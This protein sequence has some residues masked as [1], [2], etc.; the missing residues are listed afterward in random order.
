MSAVRETGPVLTGV[1]L[2]CTLY[3]EADSVTA[4]L[5]SVL[6][7][8]LLP[9]EFVIVDGGSTDGTS[10][11][12]ARYL[13]D[14]TTPTRVVHRIDQECNLRHSPGPVAKGRNVA[15]GLAS[16][17]LIAVTDAGCRLDP[18]WLEK[19]TARWRA[20]EDVDVIGG[21]YLPDARTHF[22]RC[23]AATWLRSS[24][25]VDPRSFMP[26]SRSLAMRREAWRRAGGY[27]EHTLLAEDT[28]FDLALRSSGC[29][30]AFAPEAV[31]YWRVPHS[32]AAFA[33][34]V[35]RY[36]YGDGLNRILPGNL[37]NVALKLGIAAA[38]L[39]ASAAVHPAFLALLVA[40]WTALVFR[41]AR[42][43]MTPAGFLK[44][45]PCLVAVKIVSD[46]SYLAGYLRGWA[47]PAPPP[48]MAR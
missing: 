48:W 16:C 14:R 36:G 8:D 10:E 5:D 47:K 41:N 34:L 11:I 43:A 26:S 35:R 2:I 37:R 19:I 44:S 15:I 6:G 4:F 28:L 13:R 25:E 29:T 24:A 9:E 38:L 17:D 7:M 1:S 31:V 12:I 46:A 42:H 27:P 40:Y 45:W 20:G 32:V 39:A 18:R 30:I 33:R 22:E 21:W 3:N 23:V